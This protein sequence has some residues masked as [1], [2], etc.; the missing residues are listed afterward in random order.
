M[1]IEEFVLFIKE[2]YQIEVDRL[3]KPYKVV[4]HGCAKGGRMT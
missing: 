1:A 3:L 4:Q 2:K